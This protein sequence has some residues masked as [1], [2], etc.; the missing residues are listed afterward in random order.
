MKK[1][2]IKDKLIKINS[3]CAGC[4]QY[5]LGGAWVLAN[6][7]VQV[8]K[9]SKTCLSADSLAGEHANNKE[10]EST[11]NASDADSRSRSNPPGKTRTLNGCLQGRLLFSWRKGKKTQP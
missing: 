6:S 2:V 8:T 5:L 11:G 7:S 4:L 9:P 10:T 1:N 3:S